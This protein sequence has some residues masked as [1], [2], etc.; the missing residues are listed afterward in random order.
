[1]TV[2]IQFYCLCSRLA[3]CAYVLVGEMIQSSLLKSALINISIVFSLLATINYKF[4]CVRAIDEMCV[5][6][7][8][9]TPLLLLRRYQISLSLFDDD[10]LWQFLRK[11]F[12]F[13]ACFHEKEKC[14]IMKR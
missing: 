2:F 10:F 1:M 6:S 4:L 9:L 12:S 14:E 11:I 5:L 7:Y 8:E 3:H 13:L